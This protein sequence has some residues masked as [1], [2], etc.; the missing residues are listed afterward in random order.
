LSNREALDE[1][2]AALVRNRNAEQ[3]TAALQAAG[4]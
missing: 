4:V 2:V 3:L 1:F